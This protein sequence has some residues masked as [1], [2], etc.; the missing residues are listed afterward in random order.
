MSICELCCTHILATKIDGSDIPLTGVSR[1]Q[2]KL[3]SIDQLQILLDH[4]RHFTHVCTKCKVLCK[5]SDL[6][7][8]IKKRIDK[9]MQ[10]IEL[11]K[12]EITR[13][14]NIKKVQKELADNERFKNV[15]YKQIITQNT[16]SQDAAVIDM[17]NKLPPPPATLINVKEKSKW[18]SK[19]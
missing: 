14:E 5:N 19:R 9:D 1:E 16:S 15:T 4:A 13:R 10:M 7:N 12:K 17:L 11:I 18:K 3:L 2:I 6:S 8:D